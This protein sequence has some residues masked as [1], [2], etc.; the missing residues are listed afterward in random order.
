MND[1]RNS[2]YFK[3]LDWLSRP[4]ARTYQVGE[5]FVWGMSTWDV[6]GIYPE[7]SSPYGTYRGNGI[8][9]AVSKHNIEVVASKVRVQLIRHNRPY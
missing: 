9:G 7:T 2:F 1:F 8:V 5:V 3:A 4:N 6:F